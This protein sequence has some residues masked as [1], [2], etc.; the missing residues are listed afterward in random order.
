MGGAGMFSTSLLVPMM[1]QWYDNFKSAAITSGLSDAAANASAG[2]QTLMKVAI[3]PA[4]LVVVFILIYIARR[5][6]YQKP[7]V[8]HAA[9]NDPVG[10]L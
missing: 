2:S 9:P 6:Q 5:K 7:A 4:I 10:E 3:M 8:H 1:G